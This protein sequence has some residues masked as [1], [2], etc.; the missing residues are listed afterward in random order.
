[1]SDIFISYAR[2]DRPL[3][4][5]LARDLESKGFKVWW[6]AEL[7][8]SD[9]FQDVILAALSKARAAVVLWTAASVKSNFVRDE[10][11]FALHHKKL[12]AVK[13]AGID[14]L[15]IPFGFQGQHTDEIANRDQ[16]LRAI[17]KLGIRPAAAEPPQLGQ[18]ASA[19][20]WEAIRT[21]TDP[22]QLLAWL[23]RNPAH[24]KRVDAFQLLRTMLNA[25]GS[26]SANG[27]SH[28]AMNPV[29]VSKWSA[30]ASGLLLHTSVF[31]LSE[32]NKWRSIGASLS[33]VVL[34]ALGLFAA[35]YAIMSVESY[36]IGNRHTAGDNWSRSATRVFILPLI[37]LV[38]FIAA[39]FARSFF[40]AFA[41]QRDFVAA[42]ISGV[43]LGLMAGLCLLFAA[44]GAWAVA[45]GEWDPRSFPYE[46]MSFVAMFGIGV[47]YALVDMRRTF[48]AV[49]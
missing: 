22:S 18:G 9:D 3:A 32:Q 8:G 41:S 40:S 26:K 15:D 11:R 7:V 21:T 42:S 27:T 29:R 16:I 37:A 48:R 44:M 23:E 24:D 17:E 47:L 35:G 20:D 49:R 34:T 19:S 5:S 33:L 43:V 39:R 12:V 6:D 31:Q 36:M 4:Q 13:D 10:A 28:P 2:Q 30:F 45:H 46:P 14:I 38:L 25:E 1:M